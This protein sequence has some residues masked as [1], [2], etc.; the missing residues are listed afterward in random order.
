ML[1]LHEVLSCIVAVLVVI[2]WVLDLEVD[3]LFAK[4]CA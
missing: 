3:A 4:K 2:F 1:I